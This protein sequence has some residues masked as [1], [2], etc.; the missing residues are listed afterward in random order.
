MSQWLYHRGYSQRYHLYRRLG[1]PQSPSGRYGEENNL[2]PLSEIKP[3]IKLNV[4][5]LSLSNVVTCG[6]AHGEANRRTSAASCC[7]TVRFE[8]VSA[9]GTLWFLF[10]S[11]QVR[12][13]DYRAYGFPWSSQANS[14]MLPLIKPLIHYSFI[15]VS[16]HVLTDLEQ[17]R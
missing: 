1:G 3:N 16:F 12:I 6:L 11:C 13:C 4:T 9:A 10:G 15:I 7:E 2:S 17:L 14:G 8:R 5:T